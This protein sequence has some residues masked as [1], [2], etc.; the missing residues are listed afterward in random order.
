MKGEER[1]WGFEGEVADGFAHEGGV[2][3]VFDVCVHMCICGVVI[4]E[5][6]N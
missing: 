6:S 4:R 1:G 5:N 3:G 2:L